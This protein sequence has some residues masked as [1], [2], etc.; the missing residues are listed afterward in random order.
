MAAVPLLACRRLCTHGG[1]GKGIFMLVG[2]KGWGKSGK[3]VWGGGGGKQDHQ[4]D[5][6]RQC[7]HEHV[8]YWHWGDPYCH[9]LLP[10]ERALCSRDILTP[11]QCVP[12]CI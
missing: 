12:E 7:D 8:L 4:T 1:F 9:R 2:E 6:W 3:P 11:G 10:P 5:A